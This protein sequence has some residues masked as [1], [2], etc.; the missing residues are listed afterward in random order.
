[1]KNING[2]DASA[3]FAARLEIKITIGHLTAKS[4]AGVA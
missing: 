2:K 4:V 3:L 1:M